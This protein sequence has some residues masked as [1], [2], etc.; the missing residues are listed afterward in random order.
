[1]NH[2]VDAEA[3]LVEFKLRRVMQYW[4]V[5]ELD[6]AYYMLAPPWIRLNQ[7]QTAWSLYP[8]GKE[9]KSSFSQKYNPMNNT[10]KL[11]SKEINLT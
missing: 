2:L 9:E 11:Y 6:N 3:S 10:V 4:G 5:K 7:K 8:E 1:M